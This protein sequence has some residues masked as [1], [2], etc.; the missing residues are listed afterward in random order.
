VKDS[1]QLLNGLTPTMTVSQIENERALCVYYD[2][3][4]RRIIQDWI[5]LN[6]LKHTPKKKPID[7]ED[8]KKT[9]Y[10]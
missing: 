2:Q 5:P 4:S 1:V 6:T 7:F 10:R 9:I 3:K 8:L